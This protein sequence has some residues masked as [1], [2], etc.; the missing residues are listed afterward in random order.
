MEEVTN[1]Q[2]GSDD[3]PTTCRFLALPEEIRNLI[4][5]Y[6]VVNELPLL[7]RDIRPPALALTNKRFLNE[8][9]AVFFEKNDFAFSVASDWG[10]LDK[11]AE[12][13]SVMARC[14]HL[15]WGLIGT[16][17]FDSDDAAQVELKQRKL[18][19]LRRRAEQTFSS[20]ANL[21][22]SR[23]RKW[24]QHL[25]FDLKLQTVTFQLYTLAT[26]AM[27]GSVTLVL[28]NDDVVLERGD[29]SG[30]AKD[31]NARETDNLAG[32]AEELHKIALGMTSG[33]DRKGFTVEDISTMIASFSEG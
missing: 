3:D 2:L 33:R 11:K 16:A 7:F 1:S 5:T 14:T 6:V 20:E 31:A 13:F 29:E 28:R 21:S 15:C 23:N 32:S 8:V 22:L 9:M 27:V 30:Y 17:K 4:Y 25:N 12:S 24:L 19:E 10:T 18:I 26:E